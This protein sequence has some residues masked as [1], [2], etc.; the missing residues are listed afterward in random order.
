MI[1]LI[2]ASIDKLFLIKKIFP[3]L[4]EKNSH[5][6]KVI[7]IFKLFFKIDKIKKYK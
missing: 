3:F 6:N 4:R 5:E 2:T 7:I 1:N